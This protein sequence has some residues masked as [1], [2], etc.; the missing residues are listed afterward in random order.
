VKKLPLICLALM[1]ISLPAFAQYPSNQGT[2]GQQPSAT[3]ENTSGK[4]VTLSG[5]IGEDG[6]TFTNDKDGKTWMI[7]NPDAV[8]GHEGHEVK[9]KGH[10]DATTNELRVTSVKVKKEK[11]DTTKKD[12]MQK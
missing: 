10:A 11:R 5:K 2:M 7:S 8:T 12:E 9:V 1:L 4:A 6:K 3:A